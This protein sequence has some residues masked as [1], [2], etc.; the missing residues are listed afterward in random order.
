MVAG[1]LHRYEAYEVGSV[2]V[3]H[4]PCW[5]YPTDFMQGFG[6]SP[7]VDIGC[8]IIHID[9]FGISLSPIKFPIPFEVMQEMAGWEDVTEKEIKQRHKEEMKRL[10]ELTGVSTEIIQVIKNKERKPLVL[11]NSF[12]KE[13]VEVKK[14]KRKKLVLPK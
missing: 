8:L 3:V 2:N 11:P 4:T 13:I 9:E 1:H 5:Q 6:V 7:T 10:S 12:E 14:K